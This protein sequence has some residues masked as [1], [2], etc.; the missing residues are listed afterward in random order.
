MTCKAFGSG[1]YTVNMMVPEVNYLL[2]THLGGEKI[3]SNI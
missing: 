1:E 3:P 2:H